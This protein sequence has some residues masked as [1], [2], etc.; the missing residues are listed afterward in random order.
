MKHSGLAV[1]SRYAL[2]TIAVA[3]FSILYFV[4]AWVGEDAYIN[5]RVAEQMFAGNGLV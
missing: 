5:F 3:A 1:A 2:P 4:N